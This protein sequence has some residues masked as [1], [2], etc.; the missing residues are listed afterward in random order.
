MFKLVLLL[1]C[2]IVSKWL[3]SF[4]LTSQLDLQM[5]RFEQ[6]GGEQ[7]MNSTLR[8]RKY[9]RTTYSLNGTWNLL[10]DLDDSFEVFKLF[11]SLK[12]AISYKIISYPDGNPRC[13]QL[14]RQQPVQRVSNEGTQEKVLSV[15][16]RGIHRV[17]V[18]LGRQNQSA[19]HRKGQHR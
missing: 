8:V 12:I 4:A 13:V 15:F 16:G 1:V 3:V 10:V 14:T 18:R 17:P 2:I 11:N 19:V 7:L 5:E 6:V 9:N